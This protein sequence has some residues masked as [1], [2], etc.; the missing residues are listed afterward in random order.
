MN[1]KKVLVTGGAG[2]I[3]S[4]LVRYFL[5]KTDWEIVVL[6]NFYTGS[7]SK[8]EDVKNSR[9]EVI[10]GDIRN[11]KDVDKAIDGCDFVV[12]LA[13]Q[14]GVMPSI[15]D[16][17]FDID[18]NINGLVNVLQS[19]DEHNVRRFVQASSAAP[20]GEQDMPLD[21]NKVPSPMSPY[22]ASKLAGEGYCS[23]FSEIFDFETVVL[24]F[25]NVYGPWSLDKESVVSLF[26]KKIM[27]DEKLV[28]YG[29]G[30]QTRDFVHSE[31]ICQ[32]IYLG[33]TKNVSENFNILQLGTGDEN[34]VNDLISYLKKFFPDKKFIV[35]NAPERKGEIR[36]N[37]CD[38]SKAR[39]VLGYNPDVDFENGLKQTVNWFKTKMKK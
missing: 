11:R 32:G 38:I 22:G 1:D 39:H 37:Y 26:I 6:D 34:S 7:M 33:L 19:S 21:E 31:D 9:L 14:V 2:F 10:K 12:N 25:S 29:D 3:G 5:D 35:E 13:A 18:V 4:N 8:L 36:R 27:N 16:P 20:L 30:K 24:R 23:A 28:V 17:F 15:D